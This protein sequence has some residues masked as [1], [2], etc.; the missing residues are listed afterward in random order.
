MT[1]VLVTGGAG[2]IGSHA[3]KALAAAG[4]TP[5]TLD[6]IVY[7]HEWAV[8]WGPLEVA[9]TADVE[10]VVSIREMQD[11]ISTGDPGQVTVHVDFTD[12]SP[13]RQSSLR[14]CDA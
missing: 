13:G 5:I 6:N 11:T 10:R 2:Y 4:Y 7:G 1:N 8:R 9:D 3:C 14:F 12:Q